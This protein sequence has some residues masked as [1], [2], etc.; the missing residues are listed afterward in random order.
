MHPMW[1][2]YQQLHPLIE[3][4]ESLS[5]QRYIDVHRLH[6]SKAATVPKGARVVM[7]AELER[8]FLS[9]INAT[10]LSAVQALFE[11]AY[12]MIWVIRGQDPELSLIHG[13]AKVIRTEYPALQL[14]CLELDPIGA[15]LKSAAK[16]ILQHKMQARGTVSGIIET[17]IVER[18]SIA[19]ISRYV[20]DEEENMNDLCQIQPIITKGQFQQGLCLDMLHVGHVGSY[21]FRGCGSTSTEG[22]LPSRPVVINPELYGLSRQVGSSR[23]LH[24]GET[25]IGDTGSHD[26]E[27]TEL[28]ERL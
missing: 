24:L 19:Y 26:V 6:I 2:V 14:S 20:I 18:D 13:M 15:D 23:P 9:G 5:A 27:R 16:L 12:S 11:Q 7:L 8:P 22:V 1:L 3:E 4:V 25:N 10:E 17:H 28:F 21:F